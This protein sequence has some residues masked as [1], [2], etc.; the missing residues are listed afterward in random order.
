MEF[1]KS[2]SLKDILFI[3]QFKVIESW[4]I[5]LAQG[6]SL[7]TTI[8]NDWIL[9]ESSSLKNILFC[10]NWIWL[11]S[12]KTS[13]LKDLIFVLRLNTIAS[14]RIFFTQQQNLC[15]TIQY[16]YILEAMSSLKN[17]LSYYDSIRLDYW[18]I[19]LI[20]KYSLCT[21]IEYDWI[22]ETSS[23]P[24][25]ILFEIQFN[26]IVFLKSLLHSRILSLYHDSKWLDSWEFPSL[27]YS[28]CTTI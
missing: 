20:Q 28:L 1:W 6:C 12:W 7:S 25:A 4:R 15:A 9:K 3:L 8:E 27:I 24:K 18:G 26:T 16:D 13:S 19:F 22:L 10:Y 11:D 17:F 21:T 5:F 14:S 23:S 2:S